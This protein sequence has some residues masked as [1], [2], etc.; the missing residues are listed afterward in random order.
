MPTRWMHSSISHLN[1]IPTGENQAILTSCYLP[2]ISVSIHPKVTAL[3]VTPPHGDLIWL[4]V[5]FV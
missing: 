2:Y 4:F 5:W 3:A 1:A